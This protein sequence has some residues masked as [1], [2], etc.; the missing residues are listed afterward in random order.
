[1]AIAKVIEISASS[2]KGFDDAVRDGINRASQ[3]VHN[4]RK[5]WV[6]E[7]SVVIRDDK[8]AEWHVNLR[9]TFVLDD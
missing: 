5:A 3:T 2:T 4:M 9:I 6:N 7:Q 1:M 8:I